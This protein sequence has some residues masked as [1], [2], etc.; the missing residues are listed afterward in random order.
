MNNDPWDPLFHWLGISGTSVMVT[1][2]VVST[3]CN[4][5][6]RAIPEDATGWKG[7]VRQIC[8]IIG[9]YVSSRVTNGISVTDVARSMVQAPPSDPQTD[10][11][12]DQRIA[13]TPVDPPADAPVT[14]AFPNLATRTARPLG[15][16]PLSW[17]ALALMPLFLLTSCAGVTASS[18]LNT[19]AQV[20][21]KICESQTEIDLVLSS[22][23]RNP[24]DPKVLTILRF[25]R[26]YCPLAVVAAE[27]VRAR[28]HP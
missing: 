28:T 21:T 8:K 2:L 11:A 10:A 23:A 25:L 12:I 16:T 20:V 17:L 7:V 9:L 1:L 6:A 5:I 24:D 13:D 3:I 19:G 27:Q 18:G 22:L 26:Q 4:T 15:G 14:P